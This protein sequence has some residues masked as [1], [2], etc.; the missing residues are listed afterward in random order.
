MDDNKEIIE[1]IPNQNL[2]TENNLIS[3]RNESIQNKVYKFIQ[4]EQQT[5]P[6]SNEINKNHVDQ[7]GR[8]NS[9][10]KFMRYFDEY[11][12]DNQITKLK[13]LKLNR[14]QTIL[15]DDVIQREENELINEDTNPTNCFEN[16]KKSFKKMIMSK[17]FSVFATIAIIVIL[18]LEDLR[19]IAI[20]KNYDTLV[21]V[22]LLIIIVFIFLE[23]SLFILLVKR[24][25]FSFFF[26]LDL[27]SFCSLIPDILLL[28][29]HDEHLDYFNMTNTSR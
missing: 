11:K 5:D 21:D 16:I 13:S 15:Y 28:F 27:C 24:Y 29:I 7:N 12:N 19:V 3:Q 26:W 4:H 14:A 17:L 20:H 9:F 2:E 8:K 25:R 23:I 10:I 6:I 1:I 22:I 18:F